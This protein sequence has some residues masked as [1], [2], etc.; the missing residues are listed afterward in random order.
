MSSLQVYWTTELKSST[1]RLRSPHRAAGPGS[2]AGSSPSGYWWPWCQTPASRRWTLEP[3]WN[4][5]GR[6][7]HLCKAQKNKPVCFCTSPLHDCKCSQL[8]G[9]VGSAH[10]KQF[11]WF[12][13]RVH[14]SNWPGMSKQTWLLHKWWMTDPQRRS[15]LRSWTNENCLCTFNDALLQWNGKEKPHASSRTFRLDPRYLGQFG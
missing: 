4:R 2:A 3:F 13:D 11:L 8:N 5:A 12:E 9:S 14:S 10:L 1:C 7:R 15:M 6:S